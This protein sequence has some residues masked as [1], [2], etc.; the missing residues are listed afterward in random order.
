MGLSCNIRE[1]IAPILSINEVNN[2]ES[3]FLIP[4]INFESRRWIVLSTVL[5]Y[6][7]IYLFILWLKENASKGPYC[8]LLTTGSDHL[9]NQVQ[10]PKL[11]VMLTV[12]KMYLRR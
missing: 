2:C 9:K 3:S 8:G 11:Y 7:T 5:Y 4:N 1:A 10:I 6:H 12:G